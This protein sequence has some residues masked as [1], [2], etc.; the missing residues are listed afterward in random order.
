MT[1]ELGRGRRT[2]RKINYQKF[3]KSGKV[4]LMA[5]PK[6]RKT[7]N[8]GGKK[9]NPQKVVEPVVKDNSFSD[10]DNEEIAGPS[11]PSNEFKIVDDLY[12]DMGRGSNSS[13]P[14]T[15]DVD[16][17]A[18][19]KQSRELEELTKQVEEKRSKRSNKEKRECK[20]KTAEMRRLVEERKKELQ[21]LDSDS[22][23]GPESKRRKVSKSKTGKD[24]KTS[25]KLGGKKLEKT[26]GE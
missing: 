3:N 24:I 6:R 23:D 7:V 11:K 14:D 18:M 22:D 19:A 26:V 25:K 12:S 15:S 4:E 16:S 2:V 5:K 13:D 21:D 8:K 1:R 9:K 10:K 17:N 20:A